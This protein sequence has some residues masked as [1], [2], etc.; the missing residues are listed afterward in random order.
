MKPWSIYIDI[1]A[2]SKIYKKDSVQ[3]LSTLC[4]L[5]NDLYRIGSRI[6]PDSTEERL[7]VH[8]IGDGFII[9]SDF[10]EQNLGRPISIAIALMQSTLLKGGIARAAISDGYFGDILSCYSKEIRDDFEKYG[11][12]KIGNGLMTI[13]P[14][15]GDALIN[16]YKVAKKAA[17]GPCLFVDAKLKKYLPKEEI[18]ILGKDNSIIEINWIQSKPPLLGNIL[19][20]IVSEVPLVKNLEEAIHNYISKYPKDLSEE[21]VE[22]ALNLCSSRY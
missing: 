3:A 13:F 14:V 16:S 17:E 6:F 7:F 4:Q 11:I 22:N 20:N 15:M 5:A 12:L 8:Q 18:V 21:W 2:F 10:P 19:K 1:E 9:V